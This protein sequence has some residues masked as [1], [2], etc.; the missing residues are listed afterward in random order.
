MKDISL[1]YRSIKMTTFE[2]LHKNKNQFFTVKKI[3]LKLIKTQKWLRDIDCVKW[4]AFSDGLSGKISSSIHSLKKDGHPI[5][6]SNEQGKG[7]TMLDANNP[8]TPFFWDNMFRANESRE[9]IPKEEKRLL[10]KLF[11][12]NLEQ[13]TNPQVRNEMRKIAVRHDLKEEDE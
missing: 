11:L 6:S 4:L 5:I 12:N 10:N 8:N 1:W 13:C 7:Y 3:K 2:L 9:N